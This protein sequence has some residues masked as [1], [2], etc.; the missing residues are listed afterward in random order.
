MMILMV[1]KSTMNLFAILPRNNKLLIHLKSYHNCKS[2]IAKLVHDD[3]VL[4]LQNYQVPKLT[5]HLYVNNFNLSLGSSLTV[6]INRPDATLTYNNHIYWD[7]QA[8]KYA[9]CSHPLSVS[10]IVPIYKLLVQFIF[11]VSYFSQQT[12]Y[13]MY[14]LLL[15]VAI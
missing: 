9:F 4:C 6:R 12:I 1:Q 5:E 8:L 10:S 15:L 2:A 3:T 13:S 14:K 7:H 11:I